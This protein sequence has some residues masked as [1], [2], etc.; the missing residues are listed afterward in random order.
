MERRNDNHTIKIQQSVISDVISYLKVCEIPAS[1]INPRLVQLALEAS[2][3]PQL[4]FW[5]ALD[6]AT[7]LR[8]LESYAPGFKNSLSFVEE[9]AY[10]ILVDR[11]DR[12]LDFRFRDELNAEILLAAP[13][14]KRKNPFKYLTLQ[15]VARGEVERAKD[16][17]A[18]KAMGPRAALEL[19]E[20]QLAAKKGRPFMTELMQEA[21]VTSHAFIVDRPFDAV[22]AEDD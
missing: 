14:A 11:I 6:R 19:V 2:Y 15:L 13:P 1:F 8:A 16:L 3:K 22:E 12:I 21:I 20:A 4:V 5:R 18:D 7:V 10:E 17:I 9:N